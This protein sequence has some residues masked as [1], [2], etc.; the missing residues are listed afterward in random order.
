MVDT[1]AV[2]VAQLPYERLDGDE[3]TD[4]A[5]PLVNGRHLLDL[6]TEFER[7]RAVQAGFTGTNSYAPLCSADVL[8]PSGHWIGKPLEELVCGGWTVVA[9]CTCGAW[10]CGGLLA[11]IAV[12]SDTVTWSHFQTPFGISRSKE[13][14]PEANAPHIST[15]GF[16]PF[17]FD[18]GQYEAAL[19]AAQRIPWPYPLAL[20]EPPASRS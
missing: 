4:V 20:E 10:E 5:F 14:H 12:G 17:V 7:P 1:F 18:R 15:E 19:T 6:V 13:G 11:R 2:V 16:G 3:G 9:T 8:F